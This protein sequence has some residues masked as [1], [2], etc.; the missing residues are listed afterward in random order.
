MT[1]G[2]KTFSD[3]FKD[4]KALLE[5]IWPWAALVIVVAAGAYYYFNGQKN[6]LT[7]EQAKTKATDFINQYLIQPG[8][9]ATISQVVEEG[10]LYK[11]D[12][13]VN[14]QNYSSYMTRDG[15][16]FFTS[17]IDMEEIEGEAAQEEQAQ[18]VPKSEKPQVELF[19]MSYCPYGTQAEKGILPVLDLLKD[20][21]DFKLKF[22][23]YLM[24][25]EAEL[26]ENLRQHCIAQQE[27]QKLNAYLSCFLKEGKAQNCLTSAKIDS[28]K[29][30]ACEKSTDAQFSLK[31]SF[32]DKTLWENPN[33]PP[34][35]IFNEDNTKYKITG[36]PTLVLNGVTVSAARDSESIKKVIC[37]GFTSEPSEC[38][39]TLSSQ[40]PSAG[41]G[42]AAAASTDSTTANCGQ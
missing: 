2:K 38:Q 42:T 7:L 1:E 5:K 18:S 31:K 16:K 19:V 24:H 20:K 39:T 34:F 30:A 32:Q 33:Y 17:A 40:V 36:S 12:L 11:I 23:N 29:L 22:V 21:I 25:G 35:A 4:K 6:L 9:T 28:A 13:T 37:G 41:F 15:K 27:P 8:M 10:G 3:M 14:G 26:T